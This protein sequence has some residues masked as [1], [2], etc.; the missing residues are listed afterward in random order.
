VLVDAERG[1]P[2]EPGRDV[3]A[4][5]RLTLHRVPQRVPVHPEPAG[6][7]AD[8]GVVVSKGVGRPCDRSGGE[9]RPGRGE[10]VGLGE[11]HDRA[12][13]LPAPPDPLPPA[14]P[15]PPVPERGVD[16]PLLAAVVQ[17]RDDA[18]LPAAVLVLVGL[19]HQAEPVPVPLGGQ[20]AHPGHAEHHSRRRAAL[21]TVHVVEAFRNRLLGR[22]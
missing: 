20:D 7:G 16:E 4:A 21:T 12:G 15:D 22:S 5:L 14:D 13:R 10:L 6:Q 18:T 9:Q 8:R 3:D 1:H 11:R 19:H 17:D 2:G